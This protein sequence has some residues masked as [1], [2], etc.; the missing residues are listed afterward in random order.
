MN[1]IGFDKNSKR[2]LSMNQQR[3]IRSILTIDYDG[4]FFWETSFNLNITL[5]RGLDSKDEILLFLDS[6]L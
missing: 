3:S 2:V 1:E 5:K 6:R 4:L